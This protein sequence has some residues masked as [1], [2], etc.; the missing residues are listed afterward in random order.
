MCS[1]LDGLTKIIKLFPD[2]RPKEL[3]SLIEPKCEVLHY[4]IRFPEIR[5]RERDSVLH[6]VWPHRWEFDKNPE[7]FVDVLFRLVADG[8]Q[9]L[10]S[11][12][13]ETFSDVP[14]VF[15]RAKEVI[16]DRILHWGHLE[17]KE[18]YYEVL[19][20]GHVVVST[21]LHEFFGVATLVTCT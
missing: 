6:I 5:T 1:F 10:V 19:S 4:P 12:L 17:T 20:S 3:R 2:Y 21:A 15:A 14:D 11:F 13:G 9:F 16:G 7:L 8:G 18:E